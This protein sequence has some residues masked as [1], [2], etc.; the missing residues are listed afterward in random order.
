MSVR[1]WRTRYNFKWAAVDYY[2]ITSMG[3]FSALLC[4]GTFPMSSIQSIW[5]PAERLFPIII[6]HQYSI[7]ICD[8]EWFPD[9]IYVTPN[10]LL[11]HEVNSHQKRFQHQPLNHIWW[12]LKQFRN[13]IKTKFVLRNWSAFNLDIVALRCEDSHRITCLFSGREEKP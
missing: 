5:Q 13:R 3:V 2:G 6:R 10:Q 7:F 9:F 11:S 12:M 4:S 8:N 1:K